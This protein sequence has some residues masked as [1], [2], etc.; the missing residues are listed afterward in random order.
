MNAAE[1]KELRKKTKKLIDH[2]SE[3]VLRMIHA[4]LVADAAYMAVM[5]NNA[6]KS[7]KKSKK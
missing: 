3:R 1:L 5:E 7:D 4:M 2:A 6:R